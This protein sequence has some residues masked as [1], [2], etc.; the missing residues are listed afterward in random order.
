MVCPAA[1]VNVA[2]LA[3]KSEA[4]AES[5]PACGTNVAISTVC[6]DWASP[7]RVT[8]IVAVEP[9]ETDTFCTLKVVEPSLSRIAVSAE[10]EPI[11]AS[12]WTLLKSRLNASSDSTTKSSVIGTS[13]VT[14]VSP[15]ANV[16]EP[17]AAVK[18]LPATAVPSTVA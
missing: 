18:S 9:S 7:D 6:S 1:K 13:T 3:T 11:R 17:D 4:S 12:P 8:V 14:L 5:T 10:P 15:G 2:V 16:T